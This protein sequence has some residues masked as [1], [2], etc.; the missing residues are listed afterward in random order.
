MTLKL[1]AHFHLFREKGGAKSAARQ[2]P[3][4]LRVCGCIHLFAYHSQHKTKAAHRSPAAADEGGQCPTAQDDAMAGKPPG[5]VPP[6][7][8]FQGFR[9]DASAALRRGLGLPPHTPWRATPPS[10]SKK[11][12]VLIIILKM[13]NYRDAS[14][15]FRTSSNHVSD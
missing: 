9:P 14:S 4:G 1:G 10:T 6:R 7:Q 12:R 13:K 15:R 2:R 3:A 5:P 11:R 8:G